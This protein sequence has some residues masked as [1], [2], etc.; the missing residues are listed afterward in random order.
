L[1]VVALFYSQHRLCSPVTFRH[2]PCHNLYP[3][4]RSLYAASP[5]TGLKKK[6]TVKKT[7]D[8]RI[9]RLSLIFKLKFFFPL[10]ILTKPD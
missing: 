6:Q 7:T 1:G 8:K 10:P 2:A 3:G 4:W 5:G 9:R